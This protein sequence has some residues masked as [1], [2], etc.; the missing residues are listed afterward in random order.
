MGE[1]TDVVQVDFYPK[2]ADIRS[3]LSQI[4]L[5][6]GA[7]TLDSIF[8]HCTSTSTTASAGESS[9]TTAPPPPLGSSVYLRQRDL[10]HKFYQENNRVPYH[11][12]TTPFYPSDRHDLLF[13]HMG[14]TVTAAAFATAAAV[15]AGEKKKKK[16]YRGVR[17]RHWGKWVAEIRLPQNRMRVWLGT[18]DTAEAAAYAY[19]RAAN[20]L[21]GEYARLNF[22]NLKDP[23]ELLGLADSNKLVALKSAVDA[24]IQAICQRVR[25]ERAKKSAKTT[26]VKKAEEESPGQLSSP[27]VTIAGETYWVSPEMSDDG[28]L[29]NS[30]SCSPAV[31][32]DGATAST[33]AAEAA[34]ADGYLLTRMP[35]FDPELI[36]EVLAN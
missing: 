14:S 23:S 24:K 30:E 29:W 6:G 36:W 17:Q 8:S 12:T 33:A 21:R 28:L 34:E 32:D 26:A 27:A 18:S 35:S 16:L 4:I 11:T 1:K 7:N 31:S 25:R 20:K 22:P 5:T 13:H 9:P 10:L 19:D 2:I 15:A 3:S